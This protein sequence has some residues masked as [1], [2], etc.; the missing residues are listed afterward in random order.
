MPSMTVMQEEI[1]G[2]YLIQTVNALR[3]VWRSDL[4]YP[5]PGVLVVGVTS[6]LRERK[7]V[8]GLDSRCGELSRDA[9]ACET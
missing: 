6:K 8:L 9:L 2:V 1:H 7:C 4:Y 3:P 5:A